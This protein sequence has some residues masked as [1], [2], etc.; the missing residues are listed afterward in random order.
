[1]KRKRRHQKLMS[2][3]LL[4]ASLD[5]VVPGAYARETMPRNPGQEMCLCSTSN[6]IVL[7]PYG[8]LREAAFVNSFSPLR[9]LVWAYGTECEILP[10]MVFM[11]ALHP[12]Y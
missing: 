11:I 6:K 3:N 12:A 5:L 8:M 1:M 4:E 10:G 2:P 9:A 7:C